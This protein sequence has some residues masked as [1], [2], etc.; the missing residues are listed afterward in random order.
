VKTVGESRL[1]AHRRTFL[2]A[3]GIAAAGA[4]LPIGA[5]S[6]ATSAVAQT[7]QRGGNSGQAYMMRTRKLG[8]L[9]VSELGFGCMSNRLGHYGPGHGPCDEHPRGPRRL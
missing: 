9:T 8:A 6:L 4:A 7:T 3:A 2:K 5:A 1:A